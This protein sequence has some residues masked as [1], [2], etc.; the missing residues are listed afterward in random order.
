VVYGDAE[1][2]TCPEGYQP[3]TS[4]ALCRAAMPL[5]K[6]GDHYEDPH[7]YHGNEQADDYPKGCYFCPGGNGCEEG[8]WFNTHARGAANRAAKAQPV[9]QKDFAIQPMGTVFM[10]DSDVD[11]WRTSA[12]AIPNS[13]NIGIGGQTCVD[14][15]KELSFILEEFKPARVVLVCGEN[16][17]A[18]D[19]TV[20]RTFG[21]WKRVVDRVTATGARMVVMGT[22]PEP[23]STELFPKYEDFDKRIKDYVVQLAQTDAVPP[24]VFVDGYPAF[25]SLGNARDLYMVDGLHLSNKGY[26]NWDRWLAHALTN[27]FNCVIWAGDQCEVQGPA[28]NVIKAVA[29]D[30]PTGYVKVTTEV[31]CRA[32][33]GL[34]KVADNEWQGKENAA[35]WPAGCY[36]CS[37]DDECT[38]GTWFNE[39]GTGAAH[40]G[41]RPYCKLSA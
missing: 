37:H 31:E 7:N 25:I 30:C 26:E 4:E 23:D 39:H 1:D 16:D 3:I 20:A 10:G 8:V 14:V 38:T 33:S 28:V 40:A 22:K 32:A 19:S 5:I 6:V 41:A 9:C 29:N 27:I 15:I 35:D 2:A 24:V 36:F 12:K 11:Y 21:R 18:G 17:L 13:Y 34:V